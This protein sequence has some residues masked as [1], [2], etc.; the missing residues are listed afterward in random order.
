MYVSVNQTFVCDH[1]NK[2]T[3]DSILVVLFTVWFKVV[4]TFKDDSC[5]TIQKNYWAVLQYC[6]AYCVNEAIA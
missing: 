1:S 3:E 4:V 2:T 5:V 6:T